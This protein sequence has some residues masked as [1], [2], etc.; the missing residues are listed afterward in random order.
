M[1]SLNGVLAQLKE[2]THLAEARLLIGRSHSAAGRETEAVAAY[3]AA[4]QPKADWS[5]GDEVLIAAAQSLRTL[6][7]LDGATQRLKQL[8][9]SFPKSEFLAQAAYQQGEIAQEQKKYDQAIAHFQR[10]LQ[11][12]AKSEFAAAAAYGQ[13]AARFAKEDFTNAVTSLNQL[14][15]TYAQAEIAPRGR[16]LRGLCYQRLEQFQPAVTDLQAFFASKPVGDELFDARYALALCQIGLKQFDPAALSLTALMKEKPDYT[17]AD[18]VYY[19]MGHAY[20]AAK[21]PTEAITAFRTLAEKIPDSPLAAEGSFH[22]GRFHEAAAAELTETQQKNAELAKATL[23]YT[24]GLEKAK[25]GELR[26]KLQYKLGDVLFQQEKYQEALTR[27]QALIKEF[28]Q[29]ELNGPGTFL[30]A[31]S[32]YRLDQFTTALPLFEQ[33]VVKK[34]EKFHAQALYRVGACAG[35]LK[36][37]PLSQKHY[38]ELTTQFP[39][40]E[41]LSDARYGLGWAIQNQGNLPLARTTYELVTKETETE[42]AAKA[43]FMIGELSFGEKKYEEAIE[44]FLLVAVGYPFKE[45]QALARFETGRCFIELGKKKKAIESLQVVVDKHPQHAKAKLATALLTD[46]KK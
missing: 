20:L 46:L 14:I 11:Q 34:V 1:Q 39:K 40:F 24:A 10:V 4:L 38:S 42:A 29:G 17:H 32:L 16:Y 37:W 41:Q 15:T 5:R 44:H 26:E 13:G 9:T 12:H 28:P 27:L 18:K 3:T 25:E 36:N 2:P 31:E 8:E 43:R 23:A 6:K 45:W 19:E 30:T 7:N 33:V 22:V 35:N 21:K